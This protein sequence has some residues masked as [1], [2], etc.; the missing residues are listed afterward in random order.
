MKITEV[1]DMRL[2]LPSLAVVLTVL[3]AV[4]GLTQQH[5]GHKKLG[6]VT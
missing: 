5:G 6:K 3:V 1:L 4:A 2:R